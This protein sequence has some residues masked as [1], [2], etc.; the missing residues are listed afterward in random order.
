MRFAERYG[1]TAV[2]AGASEGLGLA[3]ANAIAARGIHLVLIARRADKLESSADAIRRDHGVEVRT[4]AIDLG[5]ADLVTRLETVWDS[6]DVGLGVYNACYSPIGPFLD[7]SLQDKLTTVDVN[8]RGPLI[9]AHTLAPRLVA[10]GHGGLVLMS[11]MS[12]FQGTAMV[13]TYAAT[14]AFDTVLGEALWEEL[15]AHGVDA[16][17]CAAGAT[18]TPNFL[19]DTPTQRQAMAYPLSP[20]AVVN[21]AIEQLGNGP[22]TVP[23]FTNRLAQFVFTRLAS[24][25]AAVRFL[26]RTTRK[27]YG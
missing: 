4:E 14:K 26:S 6:E 12:G 11:S 2:V 3:W 17:V 21:E 19:N 15:G 18:T 23:G 24:R 16:M 20:Q 27:M 22:T 10:R 7:V 13:S 9:F 25:R 1:P 5:Q 8:V